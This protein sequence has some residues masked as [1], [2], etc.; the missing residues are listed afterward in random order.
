MND[1]PD[2]QNPQFDRAVKFFEAEGPVRVSPEKLAAF[3]DQTY[4]IDPSAANRLRWLAI[5]LENR[6]FEREWN[7]LRAIYQAAHEA[8]PNDYLV[9]HSW[10]ISACNWAEEWMTPALSE[11]VAIAC[12][13]ERVLGAALELS[14]KDSHLAYSLGLAYY[15]HP[16]RRDHPERYRSKAIEWFRQAIEWEPERVMAQLYLA[17]CFH[18]RKDWP[19]AIAEYEH[20]DV[21]RLTRDF[22]A[23]RAVKCREQLA[24][25][26]A[27]AGNIDEAVNRFTLFMDEIESWDETK[28]E[29][30]VINVDELV[31]AVTHKLDHPGLRHRTSELISRLGLEKRYQDWRQTV[32]S[33]HEQRT[34]G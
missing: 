12:E 23:W 22:P 31:E 14:P 5:K 24:T 7:D 19:R 9:L 20:V 13:A 1:L 25:C 8:D 21:V 34:N 33:A 17:H 30:C 32:Q 29:E 6:T 16:S 18:D 28:V 26:H 3:L 2:H 15:N 11:R 4:D 27:Y 10:G